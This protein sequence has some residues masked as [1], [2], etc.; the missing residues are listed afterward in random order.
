[1]KDKIDLYATAV[2]FARYIVDSKGSQNNLFDFK[3]LYS[4]Q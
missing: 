4:G 3:N 1:M 2:E